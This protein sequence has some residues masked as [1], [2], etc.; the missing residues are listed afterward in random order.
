L[1]NRSFE[2]DAETAST[3]RRGL[4]VFRPISDWLNSANAETWH[5]FLKGNPPRAVG[6]SSGDAYI[7]GQT[8]S[9][10]Y[11]TTTGAF[12][13]ACPG[14][15]N[16]CNTGV[17]TKL[18]STGSALVYSTY[19]GGP[20]NMGATGIAVNS[21][22]QAYV[23]GATDESF[24]T[25][26]SAFQ[27]SNPKFGLNPIFAVLNASGSGLVYATFLGGTG[28]D[29]NPGSQAFGVA[30]DSLGKAYITG[31]T[32]S[33]DFPTTTGAFQTKCGT[34][35]LCNGLWDAFV[36]KLDPTK[37]GSASLIYSTFLGGSGTD[38]GFG[39]AVDSSGNAYVTGTTGASVNSQFS[40]SALPSSDFPT[41]TGAFQTTCP[42]TCTHDSAWVTELNASGSALVYSTYL[43]GGGNNDSGVFHPIALDSALNAYVT[44]YTAATD[45][46]TKNPTQMTNAG[47]AAD[48]YVTELNANGSALVFSTYLG[49]SSLD[50]AI[51][52]ALD[53]FANM[54]VTGL[55]SS[56]NFPHTVGAF[57][58]ACPG[59]CTY[60]H[61][62]VTKIGRFNTSTSLSSSLNPSI[63]GQSVTFTAT[64]KSSTTG[65]PSGTVTFKDGT[66]TLGAVALSSGIAK[67]TTSTLTVGTHSI[68]AVYGG[69]ATFLPSTSAVLS[70]VVNSGTGT[71]A[72]SFSPISLS[73][74]QQL[75]GSTSPGKAVTLTSSGTGALT[76]SS[77]VAVGNF[78]VSSTTCPISPSTLA[79]GAHCAINITFTPS[80]SGKV[81]GELTV[82]DNAPGITQELGLSGQGVTPLNTSPTGLSFGTVTVGTTSAAKTVTLINNSTSSLT[83]GFVAS[84]D[85]S[86]VGSG[87]TP[88]G[89]S[90]AGKAKCTISVTF[91]PKSNGTIKGAITISYN[92]AFS[93]VEVALSGSGTGGP[94]S[95]LAF[96]PTS[97]SFASQLVGTS[98]PAKTVTVT[99]SSASSVTLGALSASGDFSAVA[100]GTAP[101]SNGLALAATHTCTFSVIF[102][103]TVNGTITGAVWIADNSSVSPQILNVSG[104]GAV[105]VS[106]SPTTLNFGTITVGTVSA[107][108][109]VT[110]TNNNQS[111]AVT[112][113]GIIASGDYKVA[114]GTCGGSIAAK[115]K[116]T[117]SVS[118]APTATG[119][120]N[121]VVSVSYA[122]L[123][124][125]EVVDLSGTGQ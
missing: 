74:T 104:K 111:S 7:A 77:I 14:G 46:P 125:Q 47:G 116:C 22:G 52:I 70:Q 100:S 45:F 79:A 12:L 90:L 124:S 102:E 121:G 72:V 38:I 103:P 108:K 33:P 13:T 76:I 39:I 123:G 21:S 62:F 115:S 82:T 41:T 112:L 60:Y 80:Q 109:T 92:A 101:C 25:T 11:P 32:D 64:V 95:P 110:L 3:I 42:G 91:T 51:S 78:K 10:D 85:Y 106:L 34:D 6:D 65:T 99:N 18:N 94:T 119:V 57:Q 68:T 17:V 89:S 37:S 5:H 73:F 23:T 53:K 50:E 43:G 93:P 15:V 113:N 122:S 120:I 56:T 16:G 28:G 69:D 35:G 44:G 98:S 107:S 118:F 81:L 19:I 4:Q 87:T 49:G 48:A 59:S 9:T 24:P 61:A 27:A 8:A 97:L 63:F 88:C 96:S 1:S 86:A 117:F 58:T 40:G 36:A 105:A 26:A 114:T 84:A 54:Y 75:I 55:T 83:I 71:P 2:D 31:W 66:T 20:G 29:F 30:I 67:F